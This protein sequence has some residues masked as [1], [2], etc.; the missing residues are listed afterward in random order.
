MPHSKMT[1]DEQEFYDE[2]AAILEYDGEWPREFAEKFAYSLMIKKFRQRE[3]EL[4][5]LMVDD[6]RLQ[7]ERL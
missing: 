1:I 5:A 4:Q 2:R 3:H 7:I 6:L